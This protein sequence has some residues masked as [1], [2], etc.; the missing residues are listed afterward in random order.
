MRSSAAALA[1]RLRLRRRTETGPTEDGAGRPDRADAEPDRPRSGR[2]LG[3]FGRFGRFTGNRLC[4]VFVVA[5]VLAIGVAGATGYAHHRTGA[6]DSAVRQALATA[7]PA[8][9]AIFSYDYRSFDASVANGRAFVTG[10]F[11]DEYAA[12]TATLKS[13]AV[14]EQAV[15]LAEVSASGVVRADP[16]RVELL[17]YLN[18]YRRN[19]NTEG[20]KVDQNRVVLELRR[21][22]EDWKVFRATA[23]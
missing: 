18:Q 13:T 20:E 23:I 21:I 22:G 7:G 6:R 5:I 8:A 9:K 1:R 2:R 12:T 16:E 4:L 19:V 3:W 15:V 10:P 11:A 14:S 17:V